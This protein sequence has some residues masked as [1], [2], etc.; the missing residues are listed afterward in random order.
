MT[1]ETTTDLLC[2][3]FHASS[4]K[5]QDRL[6][7]YIFEKDSNHD[8]L[9]DV[10][11][12]NKI[13]N[14]DRNVREGDYIYIPLSIASYPKVNEKYYKENNLVVNDQYIRVLVEK[15]NPF[16]HYFTLRF[17]TGDITIE[18]S[19]DVWYNNIPEQ[20]EIIIM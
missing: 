7:S 10:L 6:L 1:K 12:G 2:T 17:V 9:V 13:Y 14:K 18:S 15:I 20:S 8:Q 11:N 16:T 4:K 19:V 3:K 5:N